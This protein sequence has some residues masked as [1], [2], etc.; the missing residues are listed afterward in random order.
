MHL[1]QHLN[2][3]GKL[4]QPPRPDGVDA[5]DVDPEPDAAVKVSRLIQCRYGELLVSIGAELRRH[6]VPATHE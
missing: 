6:S 2:A 1:G 4:L 3:C 5:G